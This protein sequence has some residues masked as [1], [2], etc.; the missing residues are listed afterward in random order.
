MEYIYWVNMDEQKKTEILQ[1]AKEW[2]SQSVATNHAINTEK[3]RNPKSF[4]INPFTALYLS[5]F[6]SGNS[7]PINIAR[8]LIYPRVLG[9]SISTTFGNA[10]QKF[11]TEVLEGFA[12]T[13]SGID[14]EFIDQID[15]ERKYCQ[16]KSGPNTIN[17]DDIESI[18]GH[19]K[20]VINLARTN[21]L[22]ITHQDMIVGVIYGQ[23]EELSTFYKGITNKHNYPVHIGQDFWY[24]LTGDKDFYFELV[25]SVASMAIEAN[26]QSELN[27]IIEELAKS[28]DIQNLSRQIK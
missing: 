24:R 6:L 18:A 7:D 25:E 5:N 20:N 4:N 9:T 15:G 1:R 22:R 13:T 12:S 3:L 19:F 16:L 26:Y 23:P 2:F 27:D 17:K 14:I 10:I 28:E 21:N 11:T 8:A